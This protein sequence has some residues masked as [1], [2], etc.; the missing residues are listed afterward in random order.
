MSNPFFKLCFPDYEFRLQKENGKISIYDE[1]R[2][3]WIICTPEEWVRQN[4]IKFLIRDF[5]YPQ[6]LIALEKGLV[7]AGREYR[8][9]ALVYDKS[10]NPMVIIECKAPSIKLTQKVFDQIWHY[11][12]EISAPYFLIT[13]GIDLFMGKISPTNEVEMFNNLALYSELKSIKD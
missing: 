2:N 7:L 5:N 9:D 11:N 8:F 10:F 12:Y 1:L 4:L 3:K 13:N 6:N